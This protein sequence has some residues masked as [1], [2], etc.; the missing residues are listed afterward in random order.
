[1]SARKFHV[2]ASYLRCIARCVSHCS[3]SP[4]N[5]GP[6][7]RMSL[8]LPVIAIKNL[9]P[10]NLL[11]VKPARFPFLAWKDVLRK[12]CSLT[13][14]T[15]KRGTD[16]GAAPKTNRRVG[17]KSSDLSHLHSPNLLSSL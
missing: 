7:F 1:M 4:I 11:N 16:E 8:L 17:V 15:R 2:F 13:R 14:N 6:A 9:G 3:T 12:R 10:T 5:A